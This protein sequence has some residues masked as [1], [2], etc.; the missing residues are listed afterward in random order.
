DRDAGHAQPHEELLVVATAQRGV[1]LARGLEPLLDAEVDAHR[2]TLE[3]APSPLGKVGRLRHLDEA[4]ELAVKAP[5]DLLAVGWDGE[6]DV[7]EG[8]ERW[9]EHAERIAA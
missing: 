4:E 9:A 1:G 6:L 8:E 3:P 2:A 7:I 5:R